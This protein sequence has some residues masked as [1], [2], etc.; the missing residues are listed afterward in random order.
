MER[1]LVGKGLNPIILSR[2]ETAAASSGIFD[3]VEAHEFAY[4]P[5]QSGLDAAVGGTAWTAGDARVFTRN[6]P[7]VDVSP[8]YAVTLARHGHLLA[9]AKQA[10]LLDTIA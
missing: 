10:D 3:A 4:V 2:A 7:L 1:G 8:L 9:P 5:G 6:N